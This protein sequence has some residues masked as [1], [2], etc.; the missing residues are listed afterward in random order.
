VIWCR[1]FTLVCMRG[2]CHICGASC[3]SCGVELV[4]SGIGCIVA[5]PLAALAFKDF[6]STGQARH[7]AALTC[8][9]A[10]DSF[11]TWRTTRGTTQLQMASIR[12]YGS[13]HNDY[14]TT[15]AGQSSANSH[16]LANE[17]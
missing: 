6:P 14:T 2:I 17:L 11:Y 10:L 3:S 9:Y 1:S 8:L 15:C 7:A 16:P 5:G 4:Q 12:P 13:E